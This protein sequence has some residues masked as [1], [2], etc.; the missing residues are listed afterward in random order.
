MKQ[1]VVKQRRHFL[2]AGPSAKHIWTK[3]KKTATCIFC[4]IPTTMVTTI[5]III[6]GPA[7]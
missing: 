1:D 5:S 3:S 7:R 6:E 4:T 2:S